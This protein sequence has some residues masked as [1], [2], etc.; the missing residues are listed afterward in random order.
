MKAWHAAQR[1]TSTLPELSEWTL[2]CVRILSD[3]GEAATALSLSEYTIQTATKDQCF[4]V[5]IY[6]FGIDECK[7]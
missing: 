4:E 7:L 1:Y 3:Q 2:I 6:Q 5:L